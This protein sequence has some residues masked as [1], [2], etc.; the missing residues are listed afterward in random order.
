MSIKFT[1]PAGLK[2]KLN[3]VTAIPVEDCVFELPEATSFD[4]AAE[5]TSLAGLPI[6][7]THDEDN[8]R[9]TYDQFGTRSEA[10]KEKGEKAIKALKSD[11]EKG[12]EGVAP[13]NTEVIEAE[14]DAKS[15]EVERSIPMSPGMPTA[16]EVIEE[17][18]V[19]TK[20][21]VKKATKATKK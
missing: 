8:V 20:K 7:W 14:A 21:P 6:D 3:G 9:V 4:H 17:R 15:A 11:D 18:I 12:D 2:V 5:L 16:E 13:A 1:L 19:E 10:P